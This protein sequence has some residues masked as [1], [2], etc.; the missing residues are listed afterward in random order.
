MVQLANDHF[1]W[2]KRLIWCCSFVKLSFVYKW[3]K[4]KWHC[5]NEPIPIQWWSDFNGQTNL[6]MTLDRNVSVLCAGWRTKKKNYKEAT[7]EMLALSSCG[8]TQLEHEYSVIFSILTLAFCWPFQVERIKI[9]RQ[10]FVL[11][12][13]PFVLR[14]FSFDFGLHSLLYYYVC[15]CSMHYVSMFA[16]TLQFPLMTFNIWSNEREPNQ[17]A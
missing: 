12:R 7:N 13:F 10:F 11:R 15:L 4:S 2:C 17:W 14:S 5:N 8:Q 9:Y 6:H 16:I 3:F 1:E